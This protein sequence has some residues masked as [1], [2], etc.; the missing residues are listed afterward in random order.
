MGLIFFCCCWLAAW[1]HPYERELNHFI[2]L[3]LYQNQPNKLHYY[4]Q[5]LITNSVLTPDHNG[6]ST[7]FEELA[8]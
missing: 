6:S 4:P 5:R 2:V 7:S 8:I 3:T 1:D